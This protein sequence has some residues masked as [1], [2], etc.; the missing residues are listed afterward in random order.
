MR[1]L[2]APWASTFAA[3]RPGAS[4]PPRVRRDGVTAARH[5]RAATRAA[6]TSVATP[7]STAS[8][9][10]AG[11]AQDGPEQRLHEAADG[12]GK[13]DHA[14]ALPRLEGGTKARL[15]RQALTGPCLE[16]PLRGKGAPW[17][18]TWSRRRD[19][20]RQRTRGLVAR[21]PP[22]LRGLALLARFDRP[23]GWWLLFWPGAWGVALAGG[24][25]RRAGT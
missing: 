5:I 3:E 12:D 6:A 19:R 2:A 4:S 8:R 7:P 18:A 21:L 22:R 14:A 20:P 24:R 13:S 17:S 9:H 25:G 1:P 15:V 10:H 23:I 16:R 11:D